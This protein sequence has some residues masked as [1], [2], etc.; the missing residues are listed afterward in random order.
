VIR[1]GTWGSLVRSVRRF[2]VSVVV[3]SLLLAGASAANAADPPPTP[4]PSATPEAKKPSDPPRPDAPAEDRGTNKD[5]R[6]AGL[7]SSNPQA[8]IEVTPGLPERGVTPGT[9]ILDKTL[10]I[11]QTTDVLAIAGSA[12]GYG[13]VRVDDIMWV[14]VT[15]TPTAR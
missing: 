11:N 15:H 13:S 7:P 3:A 6:S 8:A 14:H 5:H 9:V 2:V 1:G 4:V 10:T 12:S